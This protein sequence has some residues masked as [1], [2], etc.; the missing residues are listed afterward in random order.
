VLI[1]MP[2][3]SGTATG[4]KVQSKAPKN[5]NQP[6]NARGNA[7]L[8]AARDRILRVGL[9]EPILVAKKFTGPTGQCCPEIQIG[10]SYFR[11]IGWRMSLMP[12]A[13]VALRLCLAA[14]SAAACGQAACAADLSVP[15][16]VGPAAGP[17][18]CG[19]CGC[20]GV[21]YV[22]H[23]SLESTY[24]AD[25]D[26]RN[27]DTTVPHYYFGRVRAYPRYFVDGVPVQGPCY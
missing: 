27:Y 14:V 25:F 15:A 1:S 4:R 21:A 7:R 3:F 16:A 11:S 9:T 5:G 13:M 23:R 24:G 22:Y 2:N 19:P 10:V 8:N 17:P 12:G 20:L 18:R 26:P 6:F